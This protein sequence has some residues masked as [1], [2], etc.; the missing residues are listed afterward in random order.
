MEVERFYSPVLALLLF[1]AV[2]VLFMALQQVDRRQV[3]L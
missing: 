3:S 2:A 1:L